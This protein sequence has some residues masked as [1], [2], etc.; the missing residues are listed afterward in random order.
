VVEVRYRVEESGGG[1]VEY[2]V[3]RGEEWEVEEGEEVVGDVE[4][5]VKNGRFRVRGQ[6]LVKVRVKE[7]GQELKVVFVQLN[8]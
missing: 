7:R 1:W 4:G 3:E 6:R 2:Q 8:C 5:E